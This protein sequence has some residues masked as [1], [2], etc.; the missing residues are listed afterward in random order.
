MD[1]LILNKNWQ[2]D[3]IVDWK[4]AMTLLYSTRVEVVEFYKDRT[5]TSGSAE[6]KLPLVL[7]HQTGNLK[8][9]NLRLTRKALFLRDGG[10]CQYCNN[11]VSKTSFTIDHVVPKSKQGKTT[12]NNVVVS[13]YEC[14]A[15]KGARTPE[16]ASMPLIKVPQK[17]KDK[18]SLLAFE[19]GEENKWKNYV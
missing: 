10:R 7:R 4:K 18:K 12:W 1:T 9:I 13:C 15:K 3:K 16:E 5:I 17:P 19:L 14:N 6:H 8:K 2:P 11:T